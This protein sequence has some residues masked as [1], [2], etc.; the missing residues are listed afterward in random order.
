MENNKAL[1]KEL[2]EETGVS[3]I[4]ITKYLQESVYLK[5]DKRTKLFRWYLE[6]KLSRVESGKFSKEWPR[7]TFSGQKGALWTKSK[8]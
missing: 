8:T 6:K 5:E 4:E 7:P 1:E 3:Q 2:I